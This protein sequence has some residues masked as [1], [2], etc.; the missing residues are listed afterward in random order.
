LLPAAERGV[1]LTGKGRASHALTR[2][3]L[4]TALQVL[5]AQHVGY[6]KH[7]PAGR[8]SPNS[9]NGTTPKTI[10]TEIGEVTID[11]PRDRAGTFTAVRPQVSTSPR[12]VDEAVI[13]LVVKGMTTGDIAANLLRGLGHHLSRDLVPRVTDAV[14]VEMRDW[15]SC[16]L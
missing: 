5:M 7:D 13:S 9:R 2:P 11:V 15:S 4:Q 6:D 10:R 12:Q 14:L 1:E 16:P 3:V 8:G